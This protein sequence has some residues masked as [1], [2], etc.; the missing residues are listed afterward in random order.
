MKRAQLLVV[1]AGLVAWRW[2]ERCARAVS[3]PKVVKRNGGWDLHASTRPA[4]IGSNE[5][6]GTKRRLRCRG[7]GR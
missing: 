3:P 2:P 4:G 5:P 6:T 7:V 1:G